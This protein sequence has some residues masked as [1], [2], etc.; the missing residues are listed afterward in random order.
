MP[1][2]SDTA[3]DDLQHLLLDLIRKDWSLYGIESHRLVGIYHELLPS[4]VD[5][6]ARQSGTERGTP[7]YAAA[8]R[9]A[10]ADSLARLDRAQARRQRHAR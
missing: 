10:R 2:L 9:R 8:R 5:V 7:E 4:F 6:N 3:V 1:K